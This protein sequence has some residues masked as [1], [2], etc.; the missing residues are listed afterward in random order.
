MTKTKA[1]IIL[2][3]GPL[4]AVIGGTISSVA[5][6]AASTPQTDWFYSLWNGVGMVLILAG[7][8]MFFFGAMQFSRT[9]T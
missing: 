1:G 6:N 5:N 9:K 7:I 8:G 3:S 4:I 2:V